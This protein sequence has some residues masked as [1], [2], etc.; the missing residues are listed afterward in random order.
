MKPCDAAFNSH[1]K[2]YSHYIFCPYTSFCCVTCIA[3]FSRDSEER[4]DRNSDRITKLK[5]KDNEL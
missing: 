2:C 4:K 5:H 3:I 1:K